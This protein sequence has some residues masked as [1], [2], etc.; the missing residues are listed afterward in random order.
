MESEAL[1][2]VREM[3]AEINAAVPREP[4]AQVDHAR[5]LFRLLGHDGGQV[6]AIGQ[7]DYRRAKIDELGTWTDDPWEGPTY[8][9]DAS[10]TRPIEYNN[11]LVVDTAYAKTAVT[12]DGANRRIELTGRVAGAAY[13]DDADT[14]LHSMSLDGEYVTAELVRF[15][16]LEDEPQN[17]AKAVASVAQ[18]LSESQQ[19]HSALEDIDGALFLDGAILPLGIVYWVLLD[20]A[21][22]RSPAG[23]WDIPEEIISNYIEVIDRQWER[24]QPVIGIVKTS[25]MAQVLSALREKITLNDIRDENGRLLDVP[26][27]RD[28][29]FISEV[30][31]FDNL[32]YLTY[33]SWFEHT[34]QEVGGNL[35]ELLEPFADRGANGDPEDYRR[36]FCYVRLPKTGELFRVEVPKLMV[37]DDERRDEIQLKALK[38]VAQRQGVPLAIHRA[39]RL[40]RISRKNRHAIRNM[41]TQTEYSYDY[42][43]DGRWSDLDDTFG[44]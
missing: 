19:A 28:H 9:V 13:Y 6:D 38:E 32:E 44:L 23:D 10:T 15:P 26:W 41:I 35:Y 7:P 40:A 30:L 33:T 5:R 21:G 8:G 1:T 11:G 24:D 2:A 36:A 18:G 39:D 25:S 27:T 43:W 34:Q 4:T 14:T 3:F 16:Q 22:G 20:Y 37:R 42:N 12:G 31:R 29:Q 17:V